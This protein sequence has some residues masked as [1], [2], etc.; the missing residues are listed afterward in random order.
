MIGSETGARPS[1]IV[2]SDTVLMGL[3]KHAYSNLRAEVGGMLFGKVDEVKPA[4]PNNELA[5]LTTLAVPVPVVIWFPVFGDTLN[6]PVVV[7]NAE[8]EQIPLKPLEVTT[9]LAYESTRG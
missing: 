3:E 7:N 2:I 5:I 4:P 9:A 1:N 8:A 6:V